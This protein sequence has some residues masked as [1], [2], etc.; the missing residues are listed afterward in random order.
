MKKRIFILLAVYGIAAAYVSSLFYIEGLAYS[1]P[2]AERCDLDGIVRKSSYND[3][4]E[5]DYEFI[6]SQT[7]LGKPAVRSLDSLEKLYDYQESYFAEVDF[8]CKAN[9]PVSYEERVQNSKI[10]LAPLEDGDILVTNASHVFSWRNGHAAIV[11]SAKEGKTL[12]AVVI[13]TNSK[14]QNVSKWTSYPNFAV[15]RLKGADRETRAKIASAAV[16]YLDDVPYN[17]FIGIYPMK[18]SNIA[19]VKGTQC[20]HLVW[21]AYA[22]YGYDID[23]DGG[24]IVTPKDIAESDLFEVV[25]TFGRGT[26]RCENPPQSQ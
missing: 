21:L 14:P 19:A 8:K 22:A 23:S 18:Y 16:E 2:T 25:Q 4:T 3:L 26:P 11:T 17:V 6:Y 10:L 1:A 7:G 5:E 20:A 24:L 9:S 12:E 13:G 15:L